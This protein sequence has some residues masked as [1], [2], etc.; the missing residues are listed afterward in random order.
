[1]CMS[2]TFGNGVPDERLSTACRPLREKAR[3]SEFF[4]DDVASS[5]YEFGRYLMSYQG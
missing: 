1:M 5:Q 3:V 4:D 2:E